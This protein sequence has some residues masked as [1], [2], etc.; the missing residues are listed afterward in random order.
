MASPRVVAG[1][2]LMKSPEPL[3]R[4][5]L[6]G[7]R[8][9]LGDRVMDPKAQAVGDFSLSIRVPG[10]IPTP[11]ESRQQMTQLVA[12]LDDPVPDDV[13]TEDRTLPGPVS[14]L[15]IRI[16]RRQGGRNPA[17]AVAYFHGGGFV[18]GNLDTHNGICGKLAS[19]ADC[20]V[21]AT[22]YRLAPEH[23]FPAAP[24]DCFA[25]YR[26][27]RENAAM[28]G[29]DADRIAVA[30]DSAGG[31]LA[32]VTSM[33][34][35]DNGAPLPAAQV[36]I[37]PVVQNEHTTLS[38]DELQDG[39]I[40]PRERIDWYDL[41]YFGEQGPPKGD[42]RAAPITRDDLT[43][44][45]P[46]MVITAGFDPLRDEGEAY[47]KRLEDAGVAVRLLPY[48]G[49]IHGF[50]SMCGVIPQGR[51]CIAEIAGYLKEVLG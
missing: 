46:A 17:P 20:T 14:D 49:Q 24:D 4:V 38:R 10:Y 34:A 7:R 27:I 40:I 18:Q 6:T 5:V 43:G 16:Y 15:P 11:E 1:A 21:I 9:R 36:L 39:F 45:P 8:R 25:A 2:M 23:P 28:L 50:I 48:D 13:T 3:A 31:N 33:L 30:G 47:A 29:L 37:Y 12:A 41:Q 51:A 42:F 19:Q 35:A 32:A 44:Q 26:W 22:D